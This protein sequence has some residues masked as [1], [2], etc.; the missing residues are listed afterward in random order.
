MNGFLSKDDF[1][2][3]NYRETD[4]ADIVHFWGI[5][6]M[7]DPERGD[8]KETINRTIEAGGR[9]LVMEAKTSG[10]ICGTSWMTVDGRRMTIHHFGILPACQGKGL[11]KLLLKESLE[12][13]K[14]IG[15][16]VKLEVHSTNIKAINL[17]KKFGF[18]HLGEYN[19]YI[20][21]DVSKL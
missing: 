20:I 7:G 11:S 12:F 13:V 8:S 17:Y 21:R 1:I 14:E 19:V 4:Y 3:R 18:T 5:T 16:Q 9:L 10:D 2:F 6:D 15:L